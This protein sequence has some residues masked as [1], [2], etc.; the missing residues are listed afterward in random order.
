[1]LFVA[2]PLVAFN[3]IFLSFFGQSDYC[4]LACSTLGLP[5]MGLCANYFLSP[6]SAS[7]T[8]NI[9]SGPFSPSFPSVTPPIRQI[10]VH[11]MLS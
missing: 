10:L 2:L 7:T 3:V 9:F 8:S 1:M 6:V 11:L 4:V 5:C